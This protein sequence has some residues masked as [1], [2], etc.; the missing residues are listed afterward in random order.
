LDFPSDAPPSSGSAELPPSIHEWA[1]LTRRAVLRILAGKP[2]GSLPPLDLAAGTIFQQRVWAALREIEPGRTRSYSEIAAAVGTPKATR[3]VGSA[4]GANPIPLI[5][6]CH[7]VVASGGKLGG[8]SGG[9]D[10]KKHLL[11]AEGTRL[12]SFLPA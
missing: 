3:A 5:V 2:G 11:M 1:N 6:P 10:W 12:D 4:C 8:F 9:L 7:R